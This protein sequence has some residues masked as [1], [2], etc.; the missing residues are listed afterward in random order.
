MNDTSTLLQDKEEL[1]KEVD[2]FPVHF[3]SG[4]PGSVFDKVTIELGERKARI[5]ASLKEVLKDAALLSN[6]AP[7]LS[8][9]IERQIQ[10][11][12]NDLKRSPK[13]IYLLSNLGNTYLSIGKL[14][15]AIRC[16]ERALDINKDFRLAMVSL[17]KSY[18]IE[19][20]PDEALKIYLEYA[21]KYPN[22]A[23]ALVDLTHVYL[24]LEKLD[25][26]RA[27]IDKSISLEPNNPNAHHTS[28][29]L[30][31]IQGDVD[32]SIATSRR[33]TYL[34]AR[35]APAYTALGVCYA[36]KGSHT[37]SI[38]YLKIAYAIDPQ[39]VYAAKNLAQAYQDRGDFEAAATLMTEYLKRYPRDWE[40]QNKLAYSYFKLGDNK[41]SLEC[42]LSLL[43]SP[44]GIPAAGKRYAAILNNIGVVHL[45]MGLISHAE[46]MFRKSLTASDKP[47]PV[48]YFNLTRMLTDLG[49]REEAKKLIEEYISIAPDDNT[50]L[51]LLVQNYM[52]DGEYEKSREILD[53]IASKDPDSRYANGLLV[54]LNS[55]VFDNYDSAIE[56]L[57][58]EMAKNKSDITIQNNLAYCYL[59]KG[60]I[61]AASDIL[62]SVNWDKATFAL[63]ATKGLLQISKGKLKE[64]IDLYNTAVGKAPH[65]EL[66]NVVRQKRGIEVARY[67]FM[68]GERD[69]AL[70][71]LQSV[72]S[73]K[74]KRK[75][76]LDQASRLL[77]QI[78]K[79]PQQSRFR[80]PETRTKGGQQGS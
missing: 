54:L 3:G 26:A 7:D 8:K 29:I 41:R 30:H 49:R 37:K 56:I 34:D 24:R 44:L 39:G 70:R 62:G 23:K 31:L 21:R 59:R 71:R 4:S 10:R 20:K 45:H 1:V 64:G 74:T 2:R 36:V 55:E 58:Q 32:K 17:A 28:G 51:I 19:D 6:V 60:L 9:S 80:F 69:E 18:M 75:L 25:E 42:L 57:K 11:L 63:Y 12:L 78:E 46:N 72:L 38:K 27:T 61:D 53:E 22:D 76:Y 48:T 16:F 65:N 35:F 47:N 13:N 5:T 43:S 52:N 77:Q 67:F 66:K 14:D 33:A 73:V 68:R 40:A 15:K 79:L 50:P